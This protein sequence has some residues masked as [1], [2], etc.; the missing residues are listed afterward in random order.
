MVE[1]INAQNLRFEQ[2]MKGNHLTQVMHGDNVGI[3]LHGRKLIL[4]VGNRH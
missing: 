2:P 3:Y 4:N 1:K